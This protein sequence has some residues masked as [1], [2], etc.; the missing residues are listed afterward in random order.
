MISSKDLLDKEYDPKQGNGFGGGK[1]L[2]NDKMIFIVAILSI[3]LYIPIGT[4]MAIFSIIRG[5]EELDEYRIS[6]DKYDWQSVEFVKRGRN[7]A[8]ASIILQCISIPLFIAWA[9]S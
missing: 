4:F 3:F 8:I 2:D 9:V 5:N 7:L 1:R 6:P